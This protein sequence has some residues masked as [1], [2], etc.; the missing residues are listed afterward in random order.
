MQKH[1]SP[2]T[3]HLHPREHLL[4]QE[5]FV[6]GVDTPTELPTVEI[7]GDGVGGGV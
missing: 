3:I 6:F 5:E 4:Q 1:S 7:N 2:D